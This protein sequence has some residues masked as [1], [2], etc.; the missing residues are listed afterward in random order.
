MINFHQPIY[1]MFLSI[2]MAT[3]LGTIVYNFAWKEKSGSIY[4]NNIYFQN[5]KFLDLIMILFSFR[6]L[7]T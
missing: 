3:L 7:C 5:T 2:Y 6:C 1:I 4:F